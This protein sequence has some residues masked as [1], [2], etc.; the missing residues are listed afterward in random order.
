MVEFKDLLIKAQRG[1]FNVTPKANL[2]LVIGSDKHYYSYTQSVSTDHAGNVS[3]GG[4]QT[5]SYK[6]NKIALAVQNNEDIVRD[7]WI[8][9]TEFDNEDPTMIKRRWSTRSPRLGQGEAWKYDFGYRPEP[10]LL[11]LEQFKICDMDNVAVDQFTPKIIFSSVIDDNRHRKYRMWVR[12]E[13][14]FIITMFS[15][16]GVFIYKLTR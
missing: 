1:S 5:N 8:E 13:W 6:T 3:G 16:L 15:V 2:S 9:F 11:R 4:T 7:Y 12:L 10:M 14:L